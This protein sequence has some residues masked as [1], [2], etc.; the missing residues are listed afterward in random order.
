MIITKSY[1]QLV[2]MCA[3]PG[4]PP[5]EGH[6]AHDDKGGAFLALFSPSAAKLLAVGLQKLS[7]RPADAEAKVEARLCGPHT[8]DLTNAIVVLLLTLN[9]NG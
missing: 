2:L 5:T 8:V 9:A 7:A 3:W 4:A 6:L 1:H